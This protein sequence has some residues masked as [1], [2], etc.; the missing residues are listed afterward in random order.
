MGIP[1]SSTSLRA[2]AGS[3]ASQ[4]AL[5]LKN[6]PANARD[7][8]DVGLIPGL[9]RSPGGGNGNP[10]QYSC[11]GSPTEGGSWRATVHGVEKESDMT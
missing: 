2:L 11:L 4:V 9:G 3:V 6:P 7:I 8:G 10:L 1:L 5:V